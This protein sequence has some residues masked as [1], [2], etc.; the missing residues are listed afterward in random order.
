MK[1]EGVFPTMQ[2]DVNASASSAVVLDLKASAGAYS[3]DAAF[4]LTGERLVGQH[5]LL[6][7]PIG[8]EL[9][10]ARGLSRHNGTATAISIK[11]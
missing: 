2:A 3:M 6:Q 1:L 11:L 8:G 10:Q 9:L 7:Y 4:K 5:P